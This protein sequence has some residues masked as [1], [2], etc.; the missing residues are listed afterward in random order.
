MN[1]LD[2]MRADFDA[3]L[4]D[5]AGHPVCLVEQPGGNPCLNVATIRLQIGCVHEH[6]D[7]Q[8]VCEDCANGVARG[9]ATCRPCEYGPDS[10]ICPLTGREVPD[11]P[12][13]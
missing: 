7:V 13:R 10:H 12:G 1:E 2:A 8:Q 3:M 9:V 5:A 11:E 6:V 4:A